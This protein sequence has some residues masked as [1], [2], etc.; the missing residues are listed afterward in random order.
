MMVAMVVPVVGVVVVG[1]VE[2]S[3]GGRGLSLCALEVIYKHTSH[4]LSL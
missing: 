2:G 3:G 1:G 4:S